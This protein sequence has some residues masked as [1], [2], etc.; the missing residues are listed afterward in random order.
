MIRLATLGSGQRL[1]AK[2]GKKD[3]R[4]K[5]CYKRKENIASL[6]SV[7]TEAAK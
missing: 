4:L 3:E 2:G 5:R 6:L 1:C 7:P